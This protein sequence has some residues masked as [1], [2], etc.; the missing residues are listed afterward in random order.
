MREYE[1][2]VRQPR[3]SLDEMPPLDVVEEPERRED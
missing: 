1:R 3:I 2:G